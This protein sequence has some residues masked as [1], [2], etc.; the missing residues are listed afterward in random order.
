MPNRTFTL[1]LSACRGDDYCPIVPSLFYIQLTEGA[2][3]A[4]SYHHPSI[5]TE[6]RERLLPNR[7]FTLLYPQSR[8][9]DYCLIVPSLFFIHRAEGTITA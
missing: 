9:N 5:S 2:I 3:T 8:G 7:T 1:L 6:P 4:Q